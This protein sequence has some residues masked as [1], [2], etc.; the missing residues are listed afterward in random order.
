MI[1]Y[2]RLRA[3]ETQMR[4][5]LSETDAAVWECKS[6]KTIIQKYFDDRLNISDAVERDRWLGRICHPIVQ[7]HMP[8]F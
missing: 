4:S 1:N 2:L 6:C 3:D 7:N 5:L 8:F